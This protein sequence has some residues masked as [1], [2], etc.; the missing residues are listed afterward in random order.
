MQIDTVPTQGENLVS[1][2]VVV[3]G[4]ARSPGTHWYGVFSLAGLDKF[5][6]PSPGQIGV[7]QFV[8]TLVSTRNPEDSGTGSEGNSS[9]AQ[10]IAGKG[11]TNDSRSFM[12]E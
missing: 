4:T 10:S 6:A 2:S 9:T 8:R 5:Y 3:A 12:A 11:Q 7:H 1:Y